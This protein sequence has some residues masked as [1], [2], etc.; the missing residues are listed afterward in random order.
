M[1]SLEAHHIKCLQSIL[2]LRWWHKVPHTEIRRRANTECIEYWLATRQLRWIGHVIRMPPYRLPCRLLYGALQLGQRSVGGQKKRFSIH[3]K[4]TLKKCC[5]PP[6]RLED[7]A[8]DRESWRNTCKQGLVATF[9]DNHTADAEDR[10]ARRHATS[11]SSSG[12]TCHI[13]NRVCASDV[14]L[15]SHLR[16]HAHQT[17]SSTA[18]SS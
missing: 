11:V 15:R 10:R 9:R 18:S 6:D 8:S 16:S 14:G 5:M 7:L 4:D 13:C 12:P 2:G 1:K 17:S 3:V